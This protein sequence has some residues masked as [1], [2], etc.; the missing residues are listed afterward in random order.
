ML[1][2]RLRNFVTRVGALDQLKLDFYAYF[3]QWIVD[4]DYQVY[5]FWVFSGKKKFDPF[6][7]TQNKVF[8]IWISIPGLFSLYT[9]LGT[10]CVCISFHLHQ[11]SAIQ[12]S[13]NLEFGTYIWWLIQWF[14]ME[15]RKFLSLIFLNEFHISPLIF[16]CSNFPWNTKLS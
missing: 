12:Y 11:A 13:L 1:F 5:F 3:L 14:L 16:I 6:Q 9:N 7:W 4:G 10:I 8:M 2:L 15:I